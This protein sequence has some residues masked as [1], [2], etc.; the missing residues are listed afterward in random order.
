M[1]EI[2]SLSLDG[3][4]HRYFVVYQNSDVWLRDNLQKFFKVKYGQNCL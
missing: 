1:V 4:S 3:N 2:S